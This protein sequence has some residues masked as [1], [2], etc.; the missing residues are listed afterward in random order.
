MT[1]FIVMHRLPDVATQDEVVAAG[2]AVFARLSD[3]ARL[4]HSWIVPA[5]DCFLCE[6]EAL[7]EEAIQAAMEGVDLFPVETIHL[8]EP[9]DFAWFIA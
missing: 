5:D 9:I 1:R 2:R 8:A 6:W 4:L 7:D 3:Q